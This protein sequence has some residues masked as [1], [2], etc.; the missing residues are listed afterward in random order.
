MLKTFQIPLIINDSLE[1]ALKLDAESPYL[2]QTDGDVMYA[3]KLLGRNKIIG[4]SINTLDQLN[5]SRENY[6]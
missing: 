1:L 2:G 5:S 3:R 6:Q 4:L